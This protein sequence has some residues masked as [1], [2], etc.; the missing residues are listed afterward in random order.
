MAPVFTPSC[1]EGGRVADLLATYPSRAADIERLGIPAG[2][3]V[4]MPGT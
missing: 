1:F 4:T 2:A 3:P